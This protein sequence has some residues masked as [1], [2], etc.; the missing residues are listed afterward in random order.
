MENSA[1]ISI[2]PNLPNWV[3]RGASAAHWNRRKDIGK[4]DSLFLDPG[5]KHPTPQKGWEGLPMKSLPCCL[6]LLDLDLG[7]YQRDAEPGCCQV[8]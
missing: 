2:N 1:S 3:P 8:T 6:S 5:V 4:T 7:S